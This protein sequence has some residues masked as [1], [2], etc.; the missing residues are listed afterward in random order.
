MQ[1]T[2]DNQGTALGKYVGDGVA[3]GDSG[4]PVFLR[5]GATLQLFGITNLAASPSGGTVNYEFGTIG[6]VIVASDARF[7]S[8]LQTTTEG[9]LGRAAQVDLPLPLWADALLAF[10]RNRI[11]GSTAFATSG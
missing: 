10:G 7:S 11:A 2:V 5:N 6:G 1:S 8:W 3:V 4:S 9:T